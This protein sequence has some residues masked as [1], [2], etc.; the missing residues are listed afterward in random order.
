MDP[1]SKTESKVLVIA[2]HPDDEVLGAFSY[3]SDPKYTSMSVFVCEGSSG[4]FKENHNTK[5][6]K[7]AIEQREHAARLVAKTLGNSAPVFLNFKNFSL[8]PQ[9]FPK[10]NQ[11]LEFIINEFNPKI[12]ITHTLNCNNTDHVAVAISVSNVVRS[13]VFPDVSTILN[14][15]IPS[16]TEQALG[17]NFTPNHYK[18]ISQIQLENKIRCLSFYG[19]ELQKNPGPRSEFGI[20][21]YAA[22]RGVSSGVSY[23]ESFQIMRNICKE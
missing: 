7:L 8:P 19:K 4:R 17:K 22:F 20:K 16:S 2:A 18:E 6:L 15:E 23:A 9:S 3:L 14:M 13:N 1:N 11:K 5:E 21:S 10:L 12:I